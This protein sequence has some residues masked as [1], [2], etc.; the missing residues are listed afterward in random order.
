[1][2][3]RHAVLTALHWAVC[4]IVALLFANTLPFD[5]V[6]AT[7]TTCV[8]AAGVAFIGLAATPHRKDT[9]P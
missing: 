1:M 8:V 3:R 6:Y 4:T 2:S 5:G 9:R 7:A